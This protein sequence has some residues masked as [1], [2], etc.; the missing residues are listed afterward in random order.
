VLAGVTIAVLLLRPERLTAPMLGRAAV[1]ALG[2][3]LALLPFALPYLAVH[4]EL[5]FQ[6]TLSEGNT[7]GMDLLSLLDPGEFT[8][9]YRGR[10]VSLHRS[11]GGLF[12]GFVAL[13]LAGTAALLGTRVRGQPPMPPWARR[14]GLGLA[15]VATLAFGK[16]ALALALGK[17]NLVVGGVRLLKISSL[18]WEVHALPAVLLAAVAL[19]GRRRRTGPLA[20]REWVIVLLFLSVLA[21][22]LCLSP[23]LRINGEPWGVTLSRWVYLY[24]PGGSAF[25]APGR[26][27]LVFALPL[28][29][30]AAFGGKALAER[31]SPAWRHVVP[32]AL[33]AVLLAEYAIGPVP[34]E[35][36]PGRPAVYDW[37]RAQPGDFAILQV[38]LYERASDAWAMLWALH[39]GKRVVNGHGGF[40]LA[41]W[42]E[43]VSAAEWGAPGEIAAAIQS[44]YPLKY[45][46]V[47]PA[48][49]GPKWARAV[50]LFRQ[51][52]VTPLSRVG[53]FGAD[54][55]YAVAGAPQSGAEIRRHFST[56]WARRHPHAEYA[57][58]LTG[59]DPEIHRRVE[60][61]FNG[62]LVRTH[63]GAA[64]E[65]LPL[66]PPFRVANRNEVAFRHVYEISPVVTQG[67][68]YR[69]GR[70]AVHSPVD[71][72]VRSAGWDH[73][74]T[75]SIRVNGL[76]LVPERLRGYWVAGLEPA[77]RRVV[78]L[79]VFDTHRAVD[80]SARLAAFVEG[81]PVGTIVAV[82]ALD[83]TSWQLAD[84]AIRAFR[85]IGG[86]VDPRGAFRGAH[87]L[88]GVRG[89][90]PGEALEAAGLRA[91]SVVVG[92]ERA[93]GLALE[94][95]DL[96]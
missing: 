90:A 29:L 45:V 30:L 74:N 93:V 40:V 63:E 7:F 48:L 47:H 23:T 15:A 2:V 27:S 75:V 62:K 35:R 38:P 79:D 66:A 42:R 3:A 76:E 94:A 51:G 44:V 56:D 54:E 59:E 81:L 87:V 32:T 58:R 86:Q 64:R 84:P 73:G 9:L 96:R 13:A 77:E 22:L 78:G 89:A 37:L 6:R 43:L 25:R 57:L 1:A 19:E 20:P 24:V 14:V 33:L 41:T 50:E 68:A 71:L 80:E 5:G 16:I 88:V 12:P 18:T 83:E 85:S 91:L 61:R 52:A 11:E 36:L 28:A 4:R 82:A 8:R 49:L 60:V 72:V 67:A 31:L 92:R 39:H 17:V 69:I 95:F 21:Y 46:I 55:V 65:R 10:L 34:W 70:T 53:T 26:W